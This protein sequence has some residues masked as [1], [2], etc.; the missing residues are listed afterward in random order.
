MFEDFE[1]QLTREK[2]TKIQI[3]MPKNKQLI[4]DLEP[5]FQEIET[6]QNE[7]KE[8]E[9]L[10]KQLIKDLSEEAIPNQEE[11]TDIPEIVQEAEPEEP[12]VIA[13]PIKKKSL[14]KS[15]RKLK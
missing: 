10:Y 15:A 3:T 7:M 8:A 13:E 2:I 5:T 9:S 6:L 11:K 12:E 14:T 1:S 4:Q